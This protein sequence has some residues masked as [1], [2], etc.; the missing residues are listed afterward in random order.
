MNCNWTVWIAGPVVCVLGL[1]G[2][3]TDGGAADTG[4][5]HPDFPRLSLTLE[6]GTLDN[7]ARRVNEEAGGGLV[8]MNGIGER[9]LADLEFERAGFRYMTNLLSD[10]TGCLVEETPYYFFL[11]H[12]GYEALN[13]LSLEGQLDPVYE[14]TAAAFSFGANTALYN[15]LAALSANL[16]LTIVADN[17]IADARCGEMGVPEAPLR[18]GLEALLKSARVAPD[19]FTVESTPEYTLLLSRANRN[20]AALLLEKTLTEEERKLLDRR[21]SLVFP[22]PRANDA[23]LEFR[24]YAEPLED[25]VPR[26]SNQFGV[27]VTIDPSIGELPVNPVVMNDVRI[28]TAMELL[29]RQ[30]P[31]PL[32]GYEVRSGGLHI[33]PVQKPGAAPAPEKGP[34][35]T[36]EA[37]SGS[38]SAPAEDAASAPEESSGG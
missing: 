5:P 36:P 26:L 18:T 9:L 3:V 11:Y 4:V 31:Y 33:R 1:C 29:L 35:T 8:V 28:A 32:F 22:K 19:S 34:A 38:E 17:A 16:G 6:A 14:Q 12:E 25:A 37:A 27:P 20:T 30:W 2:C 24:Y 7:V 23:T 10:G 15:A 21:V 13:T